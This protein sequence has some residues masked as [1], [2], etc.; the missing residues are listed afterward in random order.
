MQDRPHNSFAGSKAKSHLFSQTLRKQDILLKHVANAD[1]EAVNAFLNIH[2]NQTPYALQKGKVIDYSGRH[3]KSISPIQ[4]AAWA[5]DSTMLKK[6][7]SSLTSPEQNALAAAQ[8]MELKEGMPFT[9]TNTPRKMAHY[10]IDAYINCLTQFVKLYKK[11]T[12]EQRTKFWIEV[13]GKH[14]REVPANLAQEYCRK[15]RAFK[16]V[17]DFSQPNHK[18]CSMKLLFNNNISCKEITWYPLPE[19]N[20]GL[21]VQY[22][23]ARG[24]AKEAVAFGSFD[25]LGNARAHVRGE[26]D[27]DALIA[28]KEQR[29]LEIE[30]IVSEDL[31]G[32]ITPDHS[33]HHKSGCV[34]C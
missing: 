23:I 26:A 13:I 14:Q 22:A 28:Y 24:W 2:D 5:L 8:I 11:M 34:I 20:K 17:P 12:T 9:L 33:N 30:R 29:M 21:G 6:L 18:D 4:Y 16:P 3:F 10:D 1:Y 31:L 27:L 15:D 32:E 19:D 25:G 7:A